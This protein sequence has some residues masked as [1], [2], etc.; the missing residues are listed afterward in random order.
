MRRR[1]RRRHHLGRLRRRRARLLLREVLLRHLVL[2][3]L[4]LLLPEGRVVGRQAVAQRGRGVQEAVLL[5]RGGLCCSEKKSFKPA[6]SYNSIDGL[7]PRRAGLA[8]DVDVGDGEDSLPVAD[9]AVEP[10]AVDAPGQRHHLTW[11]RRDLYIQ[12]S[13]RG[14]SN[15]WLAAMYASTFDQRELHRRLRVKVELDLGLPLLVPLR[16]GGGRGGRRVRRPLV[17]PDG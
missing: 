12:C 14:P 15:L 4:L 1:R 9:A 3:L 7:T 10:V 2:L 17:G 16:G 6:F 11:K 5:F 13:C 8:D